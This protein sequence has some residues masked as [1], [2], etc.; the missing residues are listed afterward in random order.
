MPHQHNCDNDVGLVD[1]VHRVNPIGY[2]RGH[3]LMSLSQMHT[4]RLSN[5]CHKR[6]DAVEPVI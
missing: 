6:E 5:A 3:V 1:L 4:M 2:I